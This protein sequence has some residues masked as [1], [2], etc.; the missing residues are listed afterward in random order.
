VIS[1]SAPAAEDDA[2]YVQDVVLDGQDWG[3]SY[4]PASTFSAGGNLTWTVSSTSDPTWGSEAG[5][6][7][8]S[9][10]TAL[11]PALGYLA[12]STSD[13]VA[14]R[15]STVQ[16]SLGIDNL[17]AS[18]VAVSWSADPPNG[19][20]ISVVPPDFTVSGNAAGDT[21]DSVEIVVPHT[22][23]AGLYNLSFSLQTT[24]GENLP[25]VVAV[26]HVEGK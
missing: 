3:N 25:E 21:T 20:G 9:D 14:T 23:K 24:T 18:S 13:T 4:L 12:N 6:A 8:P 15:G 1:E 2:P 16:L 10:T 11:D 5:D 22:T 26:V 19:S 7:P 17:E